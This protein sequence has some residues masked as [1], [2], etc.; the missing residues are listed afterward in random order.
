MQALGERHRLFDG[1]MGLLFLALREA[2]VGREQEDTQLAW[3]VRARE[4]SLDR[5]LC[6]VESLELEV[7]ASEPRGRVVIRGE[8]P[9][10]LGKH[11]EGSFDL[12]QLDVGAQPVWI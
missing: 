1:A 8:V 2:N 12:A 6:L 10:A 3:A 4:G 7:G 9:L 11:G 5:A